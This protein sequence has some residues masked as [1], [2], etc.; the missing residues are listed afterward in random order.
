MQPFPR[1]SDI[2]QTDRT[3]QSED[4]CRFQIKSTRRLWCSTVVMVG[5]PDAVKLISSLDLLHPEAE[6]GLQADAGEGLERGGDAGLF[7]AHRAGPAGLRGSEGR[8]QRLRLQTFWCCPVTQILIDFS[9]SHVPFYSDK[10]QVLS[11]HTSCQYQDRPVDGDRQG[12]PCTSTVFLAVA[13][14]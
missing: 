10:T 1:C 7:R 8:I 13:L 14:N 11:V 4:R 3:C 6:D 2:I 12:C 5:L 9:H